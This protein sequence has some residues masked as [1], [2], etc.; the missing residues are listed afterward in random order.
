MV[1]SQAEVWW[2][3]LGEPVGSAPGLRRPIVVIQ[4]DAL[5]HSRIGT[6]VC[7]PLT[8]NL[9][10]SRAPGNVRLSA[11]TTSLPKD[12]VANVSQVVALEKA[13]LTERAGRIPRRQLELI[14]SGVDVILGR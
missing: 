5:N 2:A 10:W 1:I 9:K 6:V 12:S 4:C 7:I 11:A 13:Q 3:D 8:S 14:L